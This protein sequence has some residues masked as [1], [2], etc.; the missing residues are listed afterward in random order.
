[1]RTDVGE[2][3]YACLVSRLVTRAEVC[4]GAIL[5]HGSESGVKAELIIAIPC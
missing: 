4:P 5:R 3:A 1:M 2:T